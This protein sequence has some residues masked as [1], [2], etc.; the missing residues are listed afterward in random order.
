LKKAI[1]LYINPVILILSGALAWPSIKAKILFYIPNSEYALAS[2][3]IGTSLAV[4]LSNVWYPYLKIVKKT[5]YNKKWRPLQLSANYIFKEKYN[6]I[7]LAINV[8]VPKRVLYH[9][10]EPVSNVNAKKKIVKFGK[11]FKVVWH[12]GESAPPN[13]KMTTNQ[14]F[15]ADAYQLGPFSSKVPTG[16]VTAGHRHL[17]NHKFHPDQQLLIDD[18]VIVGSYAIGGGSLKNPAKGV[19]NIES[20]DINSVKIFETVKTIEEF[21]KTLKYLANLC[22]GII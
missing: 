6:S 2:I 1:I 18:L 20:R 3:I 13:F 14:G 21:A 15:A 17:Y 16:I 19:L 5:E 7:N 11:L 22:E 8:M 12:S 10:I 4:Y 9:R